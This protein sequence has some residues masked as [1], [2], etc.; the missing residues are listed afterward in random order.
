MRPIP[1]SKDIRNMAQSFAGDMSL[2]F[3]GIELVA[4]QSTQ[5]LIATSAIMQELAYLKAQNQHFLSMMLQ[6]NVTTYTHRLAH[7]Q[8]SSMDEIV[9][10]KNFSQTLPTLQNIAFAFAERILPA[11][12]T[13][14]SDVNDV[15][16][17]VQSN[18][19]VVPRRL[20]EIKSLLN[21]MLREAK[22]H[23]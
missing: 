17:V 16:I 22:S 7:L 11:I 4:R 13:L 20:D 12:D 6:Q 23:S 10:M 3:G 19:E 21:Q 15:A 9:K 5:N 2:R 14:T 18:G 8:L 1:T